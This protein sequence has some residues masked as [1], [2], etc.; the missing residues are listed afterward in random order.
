MAKPSSVDD[1]FPT[2]TAP[3]PEL[4]PA[5]IAAASGSAFAAFGKQPSAVP[6]VSEDVFPTGGPPE[7][8]AGDAVVAASKGT[9]KG[10][11]RD[12]PM[13]AGALA[14]FKV[15]MPMALKAAPFIGPVAGAIPL[16]TTALGGYFGYE[17]GQAASSFVPQ[18][19][20]P[21]LKPYFE[22]GTTFGSAIASAPAS[23]FL[24]VAGPTA[25]RVVT[26]L[27]GLGTT[28]RS[29]P[30][31]FM[32]AEAATAGTQG[33]AGGTAEA[34]RPGQEGVRFGAEL[35]AG[36]LPV[37][38]LLFAGVSTAKTGLNAIKSSYN[39]RSSS[40][41]KKA[42]NLL[43]EA[44]EKHG[45]DPEAFLKAL[46]AQLPSSVPTPTPG[47]KTGSKALMELEAS[48]GNHRAQFGGETVEQGQLAL[49]AYQE[50]I[51]ALGKTGPDGLIA[52]SKL[53]YDRFA[54]GL[55]TR[56]SLADANAARKIARISKDTP[57][58]RQQIGMIVKNE[59]EKALSEARKIESEL[60]TTTL[61]GMTQAC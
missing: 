12:P 30:K 55:Q 18:E 26:F 31:A 47:Q 15:G 43:L 8:T 48:L 20:D 33:I 42:T 7:P 56:L 16:V 40:M 41:E 36:M 44:L 46:R 22:G 50:L 39:N 34:F 29:S 27:S 9:V 21:R 17:A 59:T 60:W 49:K 58:A 32:A 13:L 51:E 23:F 52:A 61:E 19:T 10:A 14:G 11:L 25:G 6:A 35:S 38:K 24:P 28:A 57:E 2:G 37:G 54:N 3:K 5:E 1:L 45:E 4:T 53:R